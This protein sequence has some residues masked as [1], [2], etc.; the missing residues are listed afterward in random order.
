MPPLGV[1]VTELVVCDDPEPVELAEAG[2]AAPSS[3]VV[4]AEAAPETPLLVG[5]QVD[6]WPA[7]SDRTRKYTVEVDARYTIAWLSAP[8]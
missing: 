8:E 2:A 1:T 5:S 3:V 6:S 7:L 4:I